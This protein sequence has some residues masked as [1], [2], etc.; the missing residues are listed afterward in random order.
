MVMN[1]KINEVF[2]C[3]LKNYVFGY[4]E[5]LYVIGGVFSKIKISERFIKL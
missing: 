3:D 2:V 4:C 1:Y 5:N